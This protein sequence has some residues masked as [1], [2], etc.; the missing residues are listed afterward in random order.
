MKKAI[1]AAIAVASI[2]KSTGWLGQTL[3]AI[4]IQLENATSTTSDLPINFIS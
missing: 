3:G 2:V 1:V 4:H